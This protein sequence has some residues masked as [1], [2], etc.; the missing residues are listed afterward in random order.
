[1]FEL[2]PRLEADALFVSDLPLC[3]VLLMNNRAFPWLI[4]VPRRGMLVEITDMNAEDR[5]QWMHEVC[6]V[7]TVLQAHTRAFKMNVA[8]LGNMVRQLHTHVV[9]RHEG[10][11]AWPHP[12]WG[13]GGSPYDGEDAEMMI[14][15]LRLL[16]A[17]Y[18]L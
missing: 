8:A 16:L 3:R 13:K 12:V 15:K 11:A 9:A 14:E 1:M 4:L 17:S 18:V 5:A 2:D 6:M 7:S 10:D